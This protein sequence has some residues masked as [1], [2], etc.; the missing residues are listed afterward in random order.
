MGRAARTG[1]DANFTSYQKTFNGQ[2]VFLDLYRPGSGNT[3]LALT[4]ASFGRWRSSEHNGVMTNTDRVYFAYGLETPAGLLDARSGKA[5]YRGVAY[6]AA[7]NNQTNAQYGVK[8][9][10]SFDVDFGAQSL[11]GSLAL[12]GRSTNGAGDVDFGTFD[13]GTRIGNYTGE[14][15]ATFT[16]GSA[17]YGS[18]STR[19]YGPDGDEI[20][21]PF[22]LN[23]S[24]GQPGDQIFIVGV[25][26]AKRQ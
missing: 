16:Q 14:A 10:S 26:A 18:I 20:A 3:E 24:R 23:A 15:V 4:Y 6:G 22:T 8:G 13:F 12:Q 11:T 2:D 19:F 21:G 5:Q 1:N 9:T 7:S 25:A 17:Q